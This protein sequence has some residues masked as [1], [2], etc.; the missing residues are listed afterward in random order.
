MN[1]LWFV[2]R[3]ARYEQAFKLVSYGI[4]VVFL[5]GVGFNQLYNDKPTFGADPWKDYF[6]LLAWGFGAEATRDAVTKVIQSW[7][8]PGF[9]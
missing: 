7:E 6:A 9:K 3:G 8:I 5:V 4:A 2:L 1:L